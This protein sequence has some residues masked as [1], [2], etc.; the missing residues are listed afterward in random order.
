MTGRAVIATTAGSAQ[1]P[2]LSRMFRPSRAGGTVGAAPT[3]APGRA[4]PSRR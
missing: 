4:P 3:S 1:P 2:T